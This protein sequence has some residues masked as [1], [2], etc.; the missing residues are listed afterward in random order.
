MKRMITVAMIA[1]AC[2]CAA[3]S[4]L[5]AD[6]IHLTEGTVL[7]GKIKSE[8]GQSVI[9]ANAYGIFRI[10]NA[11]IRAI[12][13]TTTYTQDIEEIKRLGGRYVE[14]QVE[15]HYAEGTKREIWKEE[16]KDIKDHPKENPEIQENAASAPW[17]SSRL[18]FSAGLHFYDE[19]GWSNQRSFS[20][21]VAFDQGF[22]FIGGA[23]HP[24]LPGLRIEGSF[25]RV[26]APGF[27]MQG[28]ALTAGPMWA[29]PSMKNRWG[30]FILAFLPGASTFRKGSYYFCGQA[31]FGY[32]ISFGAFSLFVQTRYQYLPTGG[33]TLHAVGEEI[34]FGCNLW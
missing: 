20:G 27:L 4:S 30:C 3:V 1:A 24:I 13:R 11:N 7:S 25:N 28:F 9:F 5:Q 16:I 21:H 23:R 22:D 32:Q 29:F 12:H 14:K 6:V 15:R 8:D 34:G 19:R 10:Q 17:R 18:S 33:Y 2:A 26:I 31:L